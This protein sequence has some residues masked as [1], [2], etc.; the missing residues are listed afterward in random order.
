MCFASIC[1][2]VTVVEPLNSRKVWYPEL[3]TG[4]VGL[5]A[6]GLLLCVLSFCLL[7][8]CNGIVT[9]AGLCTGPIPVHFCGPQPEGGYVYAIIR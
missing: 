1:R 2:S 8:C 3:N 5:L 7:C 9:A 6:F 4:L